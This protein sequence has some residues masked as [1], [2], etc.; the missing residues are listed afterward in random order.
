MDL[1]TYLILGGYGFST[2]VAGAMMR[3]LWKELTMIRQDL[4][5]LRLDLATQRGLDLGHNHEA[6]IT[7]LERIC[8]E[9][10]FGHATRVDE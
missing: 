7:R 8:R 6:R 3:F 1:Q 2:L 9:L 4:E 5:A 10:G